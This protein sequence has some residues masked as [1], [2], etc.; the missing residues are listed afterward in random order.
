VKSLQ[1]PESVPR[2][3]AARTPEEAVRLARREYGR[4]A[5]VR[6][7]KTRSGGVLGFFARE[8]FVAGF[9]PPPGAVTPVKTPRPAKQVPAKQVTAKQVREA[10]GEG[11]GRVVARPPAVSSEA[12]ALAKLVEE[13]SD[14][15]ILGSDPVPAAA[16]SEVLA[17]AEAAV[18][19]TDVVALAEWAEPTDPAV[20]ADPA[21]IEGLADS[22]VRLGVPAAYRP[23]YDHLTLD[24]LARALASLPEAP[25]VPRDGG[26]VIVVVGG[27]RDA[28]AAA[29]VVVEELGLAAS[30]LVV[31]ERTDAG[32]QRVVRRRSANKVTVLVVEGS[33]RSRSL[34]AVAAWIENVKPDHVLGAVPATAKRGDVEHWVAQLGHIDA[35]ALSSL[36][37]TSSPGELMGLL[38]ITHLNGK[39]ASALRWVLTLAATT[40]ERT[41]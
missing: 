3:F 11:A 23:G 31:A 35:L 37:D 9:E 20:L 26:S 12:A 10:S 24:A 5:P 40:L 36:A 14:E 22:L 16:F 33:L 21:R 27:A 15:V 41:R 32:R 1:R 13:T 7:W 29:H 34:A 30:D 4:E 28:Q 25:V 39:R 19:G 2:Q 17:Q 38:P 6:C 8:A 18:S